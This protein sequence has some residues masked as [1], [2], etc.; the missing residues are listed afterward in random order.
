MP[1]TWRRVADLGSSRG[2]CRFRRHEPHVRTSARPRG[3]PGGST[4][5]LTSQRPRMP[6]PV[7][8][9]HIRPPRATLRRHLRRWRRMGLWKAKETSTRL[10]PESSS[11]YP[12]R[13]KA[14][15]PSKHWMK[16]RGS[17]GGSGWSVCA[18]SPPPLASRLAK[19]SRS[20]SS[21]P[22]GAQRFRRPGPSAAHADPEIPWAS[23]PAEDEPI[24]V[25]TWVL[26]RAPLVGA[27]LIARYEPPD[28]TLEMRVGRL[29]A[30]HSH[31][32]YR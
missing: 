6:P 28:I 14:T 9:A 23:D 22:N 29:T 21:R 12:R 5:V 31:R 30:P 24:S 7:G 10:K 19:S 11:G 8:G 27:H 13:S 17:P 1:R 25:P 20:R 32:T 2:L 15:S 26:E 18:S 4:Q 3:R 16:P